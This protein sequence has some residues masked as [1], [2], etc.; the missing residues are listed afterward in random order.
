LRGSNVCTTFADFIY[1]PLGLQI[2]RPGA[3]PFRH[4]LQPT[5]LPTPL[6][7]LLPTYPPTTQAANESKIESE[8][9]LKFVSIPGEHLTIVGEIDVSSISLDKESFQ[10]MWEEYDKRRGFR[11]RCLGRLFVKPMDLKYVKVYI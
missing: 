6:S 9:T 4:L 7:T 5:R 10:K 8:S 11:S 3:D 2:S 1:S